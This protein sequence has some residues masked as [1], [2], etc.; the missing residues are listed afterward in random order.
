[1]FQPGPD[2]GTIETSRA[3]SRRGPA[4]AGPHRGWRKRTGPEQR[5]ERPRDHSSGGG[6]EIAGRAR[7]GRVK[8]Q[9]DAERESTATRQCRTVAGKRQP[10]P[11]HSNA[12]LHRE[13][14]DVEGKT[15]IPPR[16][17]V[18]A[19]ELAADTSGVRWYLP[20]VG[21]RELLELD[22]G[23]GPLELRLRLLGVL[24]GHLLQDRLGRTVD[25]VL[26]LL[27]AEVGQ[28]AHL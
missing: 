5:N 7:R 18:S 10:F 3:G 13:R 16:S 19:R 2:R 17:R 4:T 22:G 6:T 20:P 27:Q 8:R 23:A 12:P 21:P 24:L 14:L 25:Q 28:R 26:G 1:M 15:Q 11:W 9:R